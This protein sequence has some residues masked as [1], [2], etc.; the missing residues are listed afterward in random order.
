MSYLPLETRCVDA[1]P[2]KSDGNNLH[3][4][5]PENYDFTDP[6][7]LSVGQSVLYSCPD[8]FKFRSDEQVTSQVYKCMSDFTYDFGDAL[9]TFGECVDHTECPIPPAEDASSAT[10]PNMMTVPATGTVRNGETVR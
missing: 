9:T 8:G 1:V 5:L 7:R 3:V 2:N 6:P 10:V 4:V